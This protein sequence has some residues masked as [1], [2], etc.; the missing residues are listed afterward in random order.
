MEK[1]GSPSLDVFLNVLK[2]TMREEMQDKDNPRPSQPWGLV[3]ILKLYPDAV[4][5]THPR[6]SLV[7]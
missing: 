3:G 7:Y 4:G 2:T 1:L 6:L 5:Q